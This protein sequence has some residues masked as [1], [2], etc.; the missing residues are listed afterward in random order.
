MNQRVYNKMDNSSIMSLRSIAGDANVVTDRE[1]MDDYSHDE[2]CG[3]DIRHF[4]E[5]VAKPRSTDEVSRIAKLCNEKRIPLTARGGATGLC[6]G[7]VP[8]FGGVLLSFENMKRIIEIDADNMT[9]TLE[10]GLMLFEFYPAIEEK[11]LF[12]PPHPGDESA[13]IGGVIATNAGGA[14]AVK[15]GVI[16]N[17]VK[18][19]EVVL[20][21]GTVV[22]LGGKVIKDSSGYSLMHLLIGSEGTLGLITKATI[23]LMPPPAVMITLVAPYKNLHE[24]ISTVPAILQDKILPLAVEFV[25][26]DAVEL[27]GSFINKTWPCAQ[28]SHHLMIILDGSTDEE[29]MALAERVSGVCMSHGALDVF[30]ADSKPKQQEILAIRSGIYEAMRNSMIEILDITVPR[31]QIAE[32]VDGVQAV[33]KESGMWLPT[34]GHAADGN[35]HTHLMH[36]Q[37]KDGQWTE[38]AGWKEKYPEVR[39]KLHSLGKKFRGIPSGEHGI[40][41]VKKEYLKSFLSPRHIDLMRGV[42]QVFDPNGILN[43]GKIFD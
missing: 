21:D 16:R 31:G 4:P 6:G 33:E 24:A 38:V 34:Y 15:Y 17:F 19:I 12:F 22:N 9:S 20:A 35:V 3:E 13:T 40:G 42:K 2:F 37:W 18:G 7:C 10:S 36:H 14:R 39:E 43:P 29:V 28:G 5:A 27:S 25:G 1:Q 30:V 41:L 26:R 8:V 32:F 23:T 11:G